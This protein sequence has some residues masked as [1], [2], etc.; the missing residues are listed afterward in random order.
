MMLTFTRSLPVMLTSLL[1]VVSCGGDSTSPPAAS[2][3]STDVA[4]EDSLPP[5]DTAGPV[6]DPGERVFSN[7][8]VH[9]VALTLAPQDWQA[10]IDEAA[11]YV[12]DNPK[13]PYYPARLVFDGDELDGD[14]GVRLK[15]HIS[16]ELTN[17]HSFPLKL[18]FDRYLDG[19]KLDGLKKLN[20]NTDFDGPPL[21]TMRDYLSYEAWREYGV[22]ASRT[23]LAQ[24][25]LNDEVLGVYVLLEQ[26]D[27]GFI[28]R[29][30][31]KPRGD[32][33]KPEQISGG[34]HFH[35]LDIDAY[36]DI[37]HKWPDE[38]DHTALLHALE[39]LDSGSLE[40]IE[41]VF[42]VEGVLTYIAGNVALGSGDFY[43][44]TGHN[45]Y[46]YEI[47]PGRFTM[48]PWDMNGSQEPMFPPLCDAWEPPLAQRLL[49]DPE[50]EAR[51]FEL[52]AD[53]LDT[54]A[55]QE[56][57]DAR[58]DLAVELLGAALSPQEVEDF[59]FDIAQRIERLTL[60]LAGTTTCHP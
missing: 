40:D 22:P 6:E 36:P 24:V 17:G 27:G 52:V 59:R 4:V 31:D 55:S 42:D 7:T 49:A 45:Y 25:T 39:V 47:S 16:I 1:L 26:V 32:L 29:H 10:I 48:L 33:Y 58:L 21:P 34:L 53:F 38:T 8:A 60:G 54:V 3:T 43:P 2:D 41:E 12:N 11:V 14:I 5:D 20:L 37:G 51:Y 28:K 23:S 19:Q 13:R 50:H 9:T 56:S 46:L 30:F 18:D 35:G 44:T 15:G 57:L